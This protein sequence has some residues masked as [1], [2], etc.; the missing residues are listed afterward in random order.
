MRLNLDDAVAPGEDL[1]IVIDGQT[2][3]AV[4]PSVWTVFRIRQVDEDTPEGLE[5]MRAF[6]GEHLP[7][8]PPERIDRLTQDEYVE[9]LWL[10]LNG[11]PRPTRPT[12]AA[13]E[14]TLA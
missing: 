5:T 13:E 3:I 2:H 7:S 10:L 6:I 8:V 9:V 1:E 11:T 14:Q 12:Q 4:K